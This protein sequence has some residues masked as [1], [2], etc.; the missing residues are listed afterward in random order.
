MGRQR[1]K[2]WERQQKGRAK[3]R[4]KREL[5][6]QK[7]IEGKGAAKVGTEELSR[8][9]DEAYRENIQLKK[10]RDRYKDAWNSEKKF[11]Q[12]L[13]TDIEGYKK[14]IKSWKREAMI[15]RFILAL[16]ITAWALLAMI[17]G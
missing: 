14:A 16:V 6:K 3:D 4:R 9:L 17:G 1:R 10:E 5:R 11:N 2:P 12:A 8:Q 13:K 7:Y 15:T